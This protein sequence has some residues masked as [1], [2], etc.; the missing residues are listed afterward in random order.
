MKRKKAETA[1]FI[2]VN[3]FET[4]VSN[5]IKD[6]DIMDGTL[7]WVESQHDEIIHLRKIDSGNENALEFRYGIIKIKCIQ[8]FLED[9][10]KGVSQIL[11]TIDRTD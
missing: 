4:I 7:F 2:G 3:N 11:V 8:G 1:A 6:F 9:I 10:F 5:A